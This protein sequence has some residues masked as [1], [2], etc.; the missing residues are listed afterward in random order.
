MMIYWYMYPWGPP[1]P[2][3]IQVWE[4]SPRMLRRQ[5]HHC[6]CYGIT[7]SSS[8]ESWRSVPHRSRM[9]PEKLIVKNQ[10]NFPSLGTQG[11]NKYCQ[12]VQEQLVAG[13]ITLPKGDLGHN[14]FYVCGRH[15]TNAPVDTALTFQKT[16]A[17]T[18]SVV[19]I[20]ASYKTQ[21]AW[22]GCWLQNSQPQSHLQKAIATPSEENYC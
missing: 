11:K 2:A 14:A 18:P 16:S 13:N 7:F 22:K 8:C 1:T 12:W 21:H 20:I 9:A 6:D 17:A 5:P 19:K 10:N 3:R 4:T 15:P